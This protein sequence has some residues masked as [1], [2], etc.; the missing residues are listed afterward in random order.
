MSLQQQANSVRLDAWSPHLTT[1]QQQYQL[2]VSWPSMPSIIC[3]IW[4]AVPPWGRGSVSDELAGEEEPDRDRRDA[5]QKKQSDDDQPQDTK[6]AQRRSP[7]THWAV[8]PAAG[9]R[10]SA[11]LTQH[12][13]YRNPIRLEAEGRV[14]F[15]AGRPPPAPQHTSIAVITSLILNLRCRP[16]FGGF[17]RRCRRGVRSRW[18]PTAAATPA[19]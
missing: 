14:S 12:E 19:R 6:Y 7:S 11:S 4:S 18:C 2:G 8:L 10:V 9:V 15:P 1:F 3:R 5:A 16:S 13:T 17:G